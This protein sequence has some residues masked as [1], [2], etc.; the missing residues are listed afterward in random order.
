MF[1]NVTLTQDAWPA[2]SP[3]ERVLGGEFASLHP[4]LRTYFGQIP[5]AHEGHG[6]GTFR[7]A[8]LRLRTLRPLF[9]IAARLGMAF[10]EWGADV[11]FGVR[12]IPDADGAVHATR[13][14]RF[15][16]AIRVMSDRVSVADG[17]LVDRL[18]HR[19]MLDV[20]LL[21]R[22]QHGALQLRS[23]RLALRLGALRLPLPRLLGV[24]LTEEVVAGGAQRVAVRVSV[25]VLGEIYGYRGTFTYSIRHVG[26]PADVSAR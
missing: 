24:E 13:T 4:Q 9:A 8:G 19:G 26:V 3:Y 25:P 5:F 12:N 20:E 7:E 14:F 10:P 18:G 17:M 23:R 6:E 16:R 11:P 15:A 21:A 22:V 1:S 2:S